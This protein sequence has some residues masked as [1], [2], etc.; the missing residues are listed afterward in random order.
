MRQKRHYRPQGITAIRRSTGRQCIDRIACRARLLTTRSE[1]HRR[2]YSYP[3]ATVVA[4]MDPA[5]HTR[6]LS[7]P[8]QEDCCHATGI[9]GRIS[10]AADADDRTLVRRLENV[11][12][13]LHSC[14]R[15]HISK[16]LTSSESDVKKRESNA[17]ISEMTASSCPA[18]GG[19]R[20]LRTDRKQTTCDA[21][22]TVDWQQSTMVDS[23][24]WQSL[25]QQRTIQPVL[26][27]FS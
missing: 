20:C 13:G 4:C 27:Y 26:N 11:S 5:A 9:R 14:W 18:S 3:S 16:V 23:P 15:L 22:V 7:E 2:G 21:L 12:T 10:R 19:C 6:Y 24:T 17:G 8:P 1:E 25:K